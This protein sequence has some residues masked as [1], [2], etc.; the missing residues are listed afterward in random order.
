[1]RLIITFILIQALTSCA[2][3]RP[4][5]ND[6]L[7]NYHEYEKS[8]S[9]VELENFNASS[10]FTFYVKDKG[11]S[12]KLVWQSA[13]NVDTVFLFNPFNT[14][15]AKIKLNPTTKE[16]AIFTQENS[17]D[18]A[19]FHDFLKKDDN[20]FLMRQFILHRP[21]FE[22]KN[23]IVNNNHW[24]ITYKDSLPS[25]KTKQISF[26]KNDIRLDILF[27]SWKK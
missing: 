5:E 11:Y 24:K 13:S 25:N 3:F 23:I 14:V 2:T 19:Q 18:I 10:K 1:M 20:I 16:F 21:L 8:I 26:E 12:G 9:E 27:T 17:A 22:D 4:Q 15:I 6:K 7:I